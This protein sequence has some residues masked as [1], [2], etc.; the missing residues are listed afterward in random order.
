MASISRCKGK[1]GRE[2]KK[3]DKPSRGTTRK[4]QRTKKYIQISG[5]DEKEVGERVCEVLG[6]RKRCA[7][8][9][10]FSEPD[11]KV[12]NKQQAMTRCLL[13]GQVTDMPPEMASQ[14]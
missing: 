2:R 10:R 8:M 9:R 7:R 5:K 12:Q 4:K 14:L 13:K 3:K 6:R 1:K 11:A